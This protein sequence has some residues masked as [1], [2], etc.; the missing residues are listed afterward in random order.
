MV[1]ALEEL[2]ATQ[3]ILASCK[4]ELRAEGIPF[5]DS[6]PVGVMIEIPSAALTS[7]LIAPHA[8]ISTLNTDIG[9]FSN[10]IIES[11][12]TVSEKAVFLTDVFI[13]GRLDASSI[14]T[15]IN[16]GTPTF[17]GESIFESDV[18]IKGNITNCNLLISLGDAEFRSN[19]DILG[20]L[21]IRGNIN[22]DSVFHYTSNIIIYSE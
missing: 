2:R 10:V 6:V 19:V 4:E 13:T 17:S 8:G 3:A 5:C 16:L 12:L 14:Y 21:T 1:S 15:P 22:V 18:Y 20:D 7:D 11:N 9:L